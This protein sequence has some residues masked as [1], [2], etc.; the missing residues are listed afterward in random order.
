MKI[1][2]V[3]YWLITMRG[4]EKVLEELCHIYPQA[5]IFTHVIEP[6]R[7]SETIRSHRIT[8]SFIARLPGAVRH[9]QLYLPLMPLALEQIDPS[10]RLAQ[11]SYA[12]VKPEQQEHS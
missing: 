4:G 12:E 6:A 3:H 11:E 8:T 9:Y 1:A 7:I 2:I 10:P 5:D